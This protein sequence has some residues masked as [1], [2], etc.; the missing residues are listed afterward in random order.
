MMT[1]LYD[2]Q[3]PPLISLTNYLYLIKYYDKSKFRLD[4]HNSNL[5]HQTNLR[6]HYNQINNINQIEKI[7][8]NK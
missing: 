8:K 7:L 1:L 6:R 3:K 4:L 2:S 5:F